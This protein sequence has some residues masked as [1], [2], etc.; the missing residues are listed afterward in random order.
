MSRVNCWAR[1]YVHGSAWKHGLD[2]TLLSCASVLTQDLT[3]MR[4]RVSKMEQKHEQ[5]GGYS[6]GEGKG[7]GL[8]AQRLA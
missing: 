2:T 1:L 7:Q 4:N 8:L 3:H 5:V 6:F